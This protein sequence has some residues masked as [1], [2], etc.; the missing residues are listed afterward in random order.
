MNIVQLSLLQNAGCTGGCKFCGLSVNSTVN[1]ELIPNEIELRNAYD[2]A[3][4]S[5]ARLELVFPTVGANQREVLGLLAQ[6]ADVIRDNGDIEL[7]VN[8]G[9]C[10][11]PG[12]YSDLA[13][14]GVRRYRNNLECSRRLF[15]ELVPKHQQIQDLKLESLALA[16]SA[17][18]GVDTGWLCGLGEMEDDILDI[19]SLLES[20][21][22]DSITLN[23]FDPGESAE[24]FG[25]TEPSYQIGLERLQALR[26][27][28]PGVELTLGGAYELWLGA[29]ASG[30]SQADGVYVGRF[31]DHG[32]RA[33]QSQIKQVLFS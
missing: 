5:N 27:S 22:P 26:A 19:L 33:E 4:K 25:H 30:I 9:T 14:H 31:L 24:V 13:E 2:R 17:G 21:S 15:Q 11:R 12:F 29:N 3:R 7:A 28:F 18:L 1:R 32:L 6:M 8:P 23:Y 16:R 10:T 20:S